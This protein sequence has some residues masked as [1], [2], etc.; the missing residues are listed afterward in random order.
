MIHKRDYHPEIDKFVQL[1]IPLYGSSRLGLH[2]VDK[3]I[4]KYIYPNNTVIL[5]PMSENKRILGNKK[6]EMTNHL[7]NVLSVISGR[8]LTVSGSYVADVVSYSDYYPFGMLQ[9][10]RHGG[11][12]RY[13]M[14]GMEQDN[15][16][17]GKGSST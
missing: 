9:P 4:A 3:E 11:S 13:G 5:A 2:E 16:V 6:F 1:E 8:K 7:G 10:N 14:N 17:K 15:E 12:Y